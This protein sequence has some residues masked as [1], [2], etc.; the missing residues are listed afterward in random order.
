ML[1]ANAFVTVTVFVCVDVN[2]KLT[3]VDCSLSPALDTVVCEDTCAPD[4]ETESAA[5]G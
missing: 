3:V 5:E 4:G 2:C 1:F